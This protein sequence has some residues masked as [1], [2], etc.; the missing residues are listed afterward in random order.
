M[1]SCANDWLLKDVLRTAWEFDGY[2]TSDCDAD[3]DVFNS[4]H[5]TATPEQ[6][7]SVILRAGTDVDCGSFM[8]KWAGSALAK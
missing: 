6:A 4:H 8:T 7:V 5:Y 2:V 1:P 3:S